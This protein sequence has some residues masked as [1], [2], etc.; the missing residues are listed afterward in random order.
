MPKKKPNLSVEVRA[1]IV[2]LVEEGYSVNQVA[3]C[4]YM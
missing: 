3:K 2:T 1:K 4:M